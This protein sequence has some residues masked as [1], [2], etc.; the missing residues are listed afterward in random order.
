MYRCC[1]D[2]LSKNTDIGLFVKFQVAI[3]FVDK[4][5]V[6]DFKEVSKSTKVFSNE[7]YHF[8]HSCADIYNF[9]RHVSKNKTLYLILMIS[10]KITIVK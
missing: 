10:F 4:R 1:V 6:N 5:S 3:K 9:P 8:C 7:T 2:L